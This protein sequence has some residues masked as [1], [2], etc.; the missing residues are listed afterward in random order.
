MSDKDKSCRGC[1]CLTCEY[2]EQNGDLMRCPY[3]SCRLCN[4]EVKHIRS[5][6]QKGIQTEPKSDYGDFVL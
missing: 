4:D 5:I 6:C 2:S 3:K 1:V